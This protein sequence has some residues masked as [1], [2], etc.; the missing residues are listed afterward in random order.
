MASWGEPIPRARRDFAEAAWLRCLRRD[1]I[2]SL[3]L[4]VLRVVGMR[5]R[6]EVRERSVRKSSIRRSQM[7][8]PIPLEKIA[9]VRLQ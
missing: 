2:V 1:V 4:R 3:D 5:I 8:K 7:P 9:V 6:W